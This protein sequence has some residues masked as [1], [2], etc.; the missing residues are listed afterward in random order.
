[1]PSASLGSLPVKGTPEPRLA[2]VGDYGGRIAAHSIYALAMV[3][4]INAFN[5][6]DRALFGLL[7]P[8]IKV[9][10]HMSDTMLGIM[11]GLAFA[12]FYALAGVP[13]ALLADRWSRRNIIAIGF[14]FW[15]LM[16]ALTGF[17]QNIGQL[18]IVRF[19]LGAGEAAGPAPSNSLVSD[20]FDARRRPIALAILSTGVSVSFMVAFPIMGWVAQH[21]GWRSAFLLAG[22]PG[23]VLALI[24]YFT[25]REPARGSTDGAPPAKPDTIR[26]TFRLLAHNPVYALLVLCMAV[27]G[28]SMFGFQAWTPTFLARTRHLSPQALGAYMGAIVGPTGIIGALAGGA[29]TTSLVK[30]D[31]RWLAWAPAAIMLLLVPSQFLLLYGHSDAAW[32]IGVA[33]QN[34]LI[35]AQMAPLYA[36]CLGTVAPQNRATATAGMLLCMYLF[37]QTLGPLAVGLASDAMTP[38]LGEA[39]L[40]PGM[41]GLIA[42][43]F[44]AALLCWRIARHMTGDG[45]AIRLQGNR[46]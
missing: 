14:A 24:F 1:M 3:T 16:T 19:L 20:L 12:I 43:T 45:A 28:I 13:V 8:L 11:S 26:A 37:G 36:L 31:M 5:N 27:Q 33:L 39:A 18:L 7:L 41:T 30:R 2:Q 23:F 22:A 34:A 4:L 46:N 32:Q 44:A 10:L 29:I 17:A 38:Q 6:A 9:D 15:S 25:V 40:R 42:A 21:H 35:S